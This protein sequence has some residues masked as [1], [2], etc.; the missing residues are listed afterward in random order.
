MRIVERDPSLVTV[1]TNAQSGGQ[2]SGVGVGHVTVAAAVGVYGAVTLAVPVALTAAV[3]LWEE[4]LPHSYSKETVGGGVLT[5]LRLT[6]MA[7][8]WL[9]AVGHENESEV[10]MRPDR[11]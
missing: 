9:A 2:R 7:A 5:V 4:D 1:Q 10:K 3:S 6:V 11:K 8:V